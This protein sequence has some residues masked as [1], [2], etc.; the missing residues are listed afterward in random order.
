MLLRLY[1]E[2]GLLV[3]TLKL[4]TVSPKKSNF[5]QKDKPFSLSFQLLPVRVSNALLYHLCGADRSAGHRARNLLWDLPQRG[6]RQREYHHDDHPRQQAAEHVVS[7][8]R[9]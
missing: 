6:Q 4:P 5:T 1:E 2:S 9:G 8:I 3:I 7:E